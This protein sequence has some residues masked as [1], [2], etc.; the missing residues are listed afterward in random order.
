MPGILLNQ[1]HNGSNTEIMLLKITL[2]ADIPF[3]KCKR[4]NS[5]WQCLFQLEVY[6]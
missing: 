1:A 3:L 5:D 4:V 2:A 6:I